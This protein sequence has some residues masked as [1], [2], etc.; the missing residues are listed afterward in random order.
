[1]LKQKLEK[2][3]KSRNELRQNSDLLESKVPHPTYVGPVRGEVCCG[4][5]WGTEH[6]LA[7]LGVLQE[8]LQ[9][10]DKVPAALVPNLQ[11]RR[12]GCRHRKCLLRPQ[13]RRVQTR[14]SHLCVLAPKW[15]VSEVTKAP[16]TAGVP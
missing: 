13:G 3:E 5:S 16:V 15:G 1:M 6:R 7:L 2:S 12:L 14:G 10:S 9:R 11:R 4:G 8:P